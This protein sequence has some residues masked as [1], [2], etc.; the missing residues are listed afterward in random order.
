MRQTQI[1]SFIKIESGPPLGSFKILTGNY[2][3]WREISE[4]RTNLQPDYEALH[5]YTLVRTKGARAE[6]EI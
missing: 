1:L 5:V 2:Y 4:S 3:F 6:K